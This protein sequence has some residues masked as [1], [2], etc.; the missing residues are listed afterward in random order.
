MANELA[1]RDLNHTPVLLG[2]D[3]N[4][5]VKQVNVVSGEVLGAGI[6]YP[7]RGDE[8]AKRDENQTPCALIKSGGYTVNLRLNENGQIIF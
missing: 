4:G 1:L 2:I 8:L 7:I 6:S 3:P 5:E